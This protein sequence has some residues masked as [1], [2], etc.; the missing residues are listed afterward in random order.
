MSNQLM[1]RLL[2]ADFLA[3]FG[4][5]VSG[6]LYIFFASNYFELPGHASLAL[7]LYFVASFLAMPL[8]MKLA[9]KQGKAR[10]LIIALGYGALINLI[11]IPL[12]EPGNAVVLWCFTLSYGIAFGDAHDNQQ[13]GRC[14][15]CW[16]LFYD[17]RSSF[18]LSTWRREF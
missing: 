18:C 9:V 17:S 10:A 15:G 2:A 5:A 14:R 16:P 13:T 4:T 12:A 3:G 1:W 8:W 11:I 6:A 7:L